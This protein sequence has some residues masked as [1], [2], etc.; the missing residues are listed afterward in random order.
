MAVDV[1]AQLEGGMYHAKLLS[2]NARGQR[3]HR[4]DGTVSRDTPWSAFKS[5]RKMDGFY[6]MKIQWEDRLRHRSPGERAP[7]PIHQPLSRYRLHI[8]FRRNSQEWKSS[9]QPRAVFVSREIRKAEGMDRFRELQEKRRRHIVPPATK[10]EASLQTTAATAAVAP[11]AAPTGHTSVDQMS[12]LPPPWWIVCVHRCL[13]LPNDTP[14]VTSSAA[15]SRAVGSSSSAPA[16]S[17]SRAKQ[18]SP[19]AVELEAQKRRMQAAEMAKVEREERQR[20]A[21]EAVSIDGAA[22]D[23]A[24]AIRMTAKKLTADTEAATGTGDGPVTGHNNGAGAGRMSSVTAAAEDAT[25]TDW[26]AA[27]VTVADDEAE[28]STAAADR[29]A[30]EAAELALESRDSVVAATMVAWLEADEASKGEQIAPAAA[31]RS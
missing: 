1:P 26:K 27:V 30:Q 22:A 3:S 6:N 19:W 16:P 13:R 28:T 14:V 8:G 23:R 21:V 29:D 4:D 17:R 25:S 5:K 15:S 31:E 11:I 2:V 7:I 18:K 20:A 12:K 10:P 24:A 9:R